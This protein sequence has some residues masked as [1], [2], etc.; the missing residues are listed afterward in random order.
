M[1]A[2]SRPFTFCLP[3][4]LGELETLKDE[5]DGEEELLLVVPRAQL[6]QVRRRTEPG[7]HCLFLAFT[8]PCTRWCGQSRLD[9]CLRKQEEVQ[10][11]LDMTEKEMEKEKENR[12]R[13]RGEWERERDT[14]REVLS[15]LRDGMRENCEKMEKMEGTHKVCLTFDPQNSPA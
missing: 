12:R 6:L 11:V 2:R 4:P 5:E 15:Q 9:E 13:E 7:F 8:P 10:R 3:K 14:M 1:C